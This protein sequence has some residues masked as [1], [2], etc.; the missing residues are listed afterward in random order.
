MSKNAEDIFPRDP[1][2]PEMEN[3]CRD[4]PAPELIGYH[5]RPIPRGVFG[6][7]SKVLEEMAEC[8]DAHDQ[9]SSVMLILELSDLVGAIQGFLA[10]HNLTTKDIRTGPAMCTLISWTQLRISFDDLRRAKNHVATLTELD[11]VLENIERFLPRWNLELQDLERMAHATH[12]AFRSGQRKRKDG[13]ET[14]D[15]PTPA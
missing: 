7:I 9:G 5:L 12:R 10:A 14:L 15:F 3:P 1:R 4:V 6:N 2:L 13:G 8:E 11:A